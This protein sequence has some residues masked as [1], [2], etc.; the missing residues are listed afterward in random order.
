LASSAVEAAAAT[1]VDVFLNVNTGPG[2]G[3]AVVGHVAD[4]LTSSAGQSL[5]APVAGC[6]LGSDATLLPVAKTMRWGGVA[7]LG[8]LFAALISIVPV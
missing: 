7:R 1:E 2:A 3:S 5:R 8:G 6:Y 4:S